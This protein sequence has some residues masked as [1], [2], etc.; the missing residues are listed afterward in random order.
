MSKMLHGYSTF[1]EE[2]IILEFPILLTRF[3]SF[4]SATINQKQSTLILCFNERRSAQNMTEKNLLFFRQL[5]RKW[6]RLH[7]RAIFSPQRSI[8]EEQSG[9]TL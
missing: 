8:F 6:K 5:N 3:G 7:E 2:L 4:C 1:D 9:Y